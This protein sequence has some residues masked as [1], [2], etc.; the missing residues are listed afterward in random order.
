MPDVTVTA[1][2]GAKR[3]GSAG[4]GLCTG[5]RLA[6]AGSEASIVKQNRAQLWLA[7]AVEVQ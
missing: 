6:G 3:H 7:L 4:S 2:L 5:S 1:A